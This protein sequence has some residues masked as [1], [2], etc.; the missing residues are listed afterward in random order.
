MNARHPSQD[1]G[2]PPGQRPGPH[3]GPHPGPLRR[4]GPRP[5]LLHLM[6]AGMRHGATPAAML[7]AMQAAMTHASS[8]ASSTDS[9]QSSNAWSTWSAPRWSSADAAARA[10]RIQDGLAAAGADPTTLSGAVLAELLRQDAAL[11]AGIAAYRRHP[12]TRTLADPP[13]L[14][15]EGSSRLLDYGATHPAAASGP[16]I[17][18]VPSL[19]NRA[20]VLD[21]TE[22]GSFLRFLAARG[23]RPLLLDWGWPGEAERRFDLTDVI[24]GRLER[25]LAASAAI[26]AGPVI[27]AGYCMGGLLGLAAAQ[28]RPDLVCG[29]AALATPWDF[30]AADAARAKSA[31]MLL[32]LLEPAMAFHD[33]VPVD[34]LQILF[35][36]LDPWGVAAKFRAFGRL[37]QDSPRARLFVALEDWLADGIPLAAPVARDCIGG[38]YGRNEPAR[39]AWTV[40]GQVVDPRS[41]AVPAFVAVPGRDRIVPPESA[42][43]LAGLIPGAVL[44]EPAAGHIGMV[45]GGG[46]EAALWRP[47]ADWAQGL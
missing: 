9:T 7:G 8:S 27:L 22:G 18:V 28:R 13:S 34:G 11:I 46:A 5:L 37:A 4:R 47:F 26:A 15:A 32:P 36:A 17:L 24:A 16:P 40:A 33:A 20:H 23:L 21:L 42:R 39:R 41:I 35:T 14:W 1:P 12:Y 10:R 19:V 3:P 38:W 30:H 44:H 29:V 2:L 31:A 6:L 45:A 43:P 25:A